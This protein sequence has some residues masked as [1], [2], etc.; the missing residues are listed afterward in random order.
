[1]VGQPARSQARGSAS[2]AA[3]RL[4]ESLITLGAAPP[5]HVAFAMLGL[6]PDLQQ[7]AEAAATRLRRVAA[8]LISRRIATDVRL[9]MARLHGQ[10]RESQDE[11]RELTATQDAVFLP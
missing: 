4:I 2:S 9:E 11:I 10:L 8:R 1:M 7:D 3:P 5:E 6:P